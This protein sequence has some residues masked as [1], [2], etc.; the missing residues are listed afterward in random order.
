LLQQSLTKKV[1]VFAKKI[2]C[3]TEIGPKYFDKFKLE[4]G[5]T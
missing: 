3:G 1:L 5:P 4:P 2:L